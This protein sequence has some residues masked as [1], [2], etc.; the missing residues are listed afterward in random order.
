MI[1][2]FERNLVL[3]VADSDADFKRVCMTDSTGHA[4][5]RLPLAHAVKVGVVIGASLDGDVTPVVSYSS[6]LI[7]MARFHWLLR[8]RWR[9]IGQVI[10][11]L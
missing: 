7:S 9:L 10:S 1:V 3:P 6:W 5:R 8:E 11:P 2:I 4:H